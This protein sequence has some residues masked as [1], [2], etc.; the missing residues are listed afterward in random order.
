LLASGLYMGVTS[1][2][3]T[4][5]ILNRPGLISIV[6]TMLS[7]VSA[8]LMYRYLT[9]V[10]E[11]N[12]NA[13]LRALAHENRMDVISAVVVLSGIVMADF[14]WPE[15]DHLAAFLVSLLVVKMGAEV[16][17]DA[18]KG[19]LDVSV[20]QDVLADIS[21]TVR[22]TPGIEDVQLV[23]G[24]SLGELWEIYLHVTVD[25]NKTIGE[26]EDV[27][28]LLR[29]RVHKAFAQVQHVWVVTNP[30]RKADDDGGDYWSQHLFALP[31]DGEDAG[32][33]ADDKAPATP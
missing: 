6:G 28:D 5:G 19:L 31:R 10:A 25:E 27:V 4:Q 9:C 14:V 21:R 24:R 23:R 29:K 8:F 33:G 7:G 13:V 17:W 26:T 22:L 2:S 3:D 12:N 11:R 1:F 18:V 16:V 30:E 20:P 32:V 15:A